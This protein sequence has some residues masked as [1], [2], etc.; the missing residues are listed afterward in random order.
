M[1]VDL[2]FVPEGQQPELRLLV[3]GSEPASPE[4]VAENPRAQ[5]VRLR[6]AERVRDAA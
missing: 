6:A 1:P 5:S 2:P 3:R 4:E